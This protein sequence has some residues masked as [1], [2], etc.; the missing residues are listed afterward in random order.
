MRCD[1]ISLFFLPRLFVRSLVSSYLLPSSLHFIGG[2]ISSFARPFALVRPHVSPSFLDARSLHHA[3]RQLRLRQ[4]S[5]GRS[6]QSLLTW[7][8]YYL[9]ALYRSGT[10]VVSNSL[11]VGPPCP[12]QILIYLCFTS[13]SYCILIYTVVISYTN[14]SGSATTI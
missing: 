10:T 14:S 3:I 2:A 5:A 12:L 7:I 11:Q 4:D 9:Q 1:C 13:Y 6:K 8:P